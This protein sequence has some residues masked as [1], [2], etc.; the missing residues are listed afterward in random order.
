MRAAIVG[1]G[2]IGKKRAN[3]C[4]GAQVT[5][6]CDLNLGRAQSLAKEHNARATSDWLETVASPDVDVVFV[7]TTHDMLAA[8]AEAAAKAGK[9][10]LIEKPGARCAAELE[11]VK[12]AAA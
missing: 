2:G 1:C 7:A 9:H 4:T 3:A 10:V 5:V 12:A 11:A 8:V 6:C